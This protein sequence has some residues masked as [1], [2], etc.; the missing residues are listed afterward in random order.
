MAE[1]EYLHVC[2]SAFMAEG[3]KHCIIGIFDVISA[4][5]FPAT[6]PTLTIAVRLRGQAHEV[7]PLR[8]ELGRPNGE[9]LGPPVQATVTVDEGG[10]AFINM[11][12]VGTQFPEPGRYTVKISSG[13]RTLASHSLRL[14][15]LPPQQGILPQ[16]TLEKLH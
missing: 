14:Q 10:S 4:M 3:G 11:N 15:K 8:I 6:H 12:V 9:A 16:T 1:V 13:T 7:V 5:S 2:D